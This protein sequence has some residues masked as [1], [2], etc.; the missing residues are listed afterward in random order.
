MESFQIQQTQ[1]APQPLSI[2]SHRHVFFA[3]N[4]QGACQR[5]KAGLLAASPAAL[6][7]FMQQVQRICETCCV[8]NCPV[9]RPKHE[10]LR[11]FPI[12]PVTIYWFWEILIDLVYAFQGFLGHIE[13]HG[14]TCKSRWRTAG[15]K[16]KHPGLYTRDLLHALFGW[17]HNNNEDTPTKTAAARQGYHFPTG[18]AT[19]FSANKSCSE[20]R[21]AQPLPWYCSF[22][23]KRLEIKTLK[24]AL[25]EVTRVLPKMCT[26]QHKNQP[27]L[28]V[29]NKKVSE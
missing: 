15:R 23:R 6:S 7:Y 8:E 22:T 14:C 2:T 21:L 18:P 4:M 26:Y 17:P 16:K 5:W 10:N 3:A 13:S 25:N 28:L 27:K 9:R 19:P 20:L 12:I 29:L 24:L 11:Q 1:S